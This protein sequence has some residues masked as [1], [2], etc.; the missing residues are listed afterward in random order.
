VT[1]D[2]EV[3]FAFADAREQP[4]LRAS[5]PMRLAA[6]TAA[7]TVSLELAGLWLPDDAVLRRVPQVK[8]A[9]AAE[10]RSANTSPAVFGVTSAA[11]DLLAAAPDAHDTAAALRARLDELRGRAYALAD[12][13]VPHEHV[14]ERLALRARSY[15]LTRAATTAAVVA[16]GGRAMSL[17]GTAQRLARKGRFLL[18]QGQTAAVRRAHLAALGGQRVSRRRTPGRRRGTRPTSGPSRPWPAHPGPGARRRTPP[19]ATN[20]AETPPEIAPT[21]S[22]P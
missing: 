14:A 16:G 20:R 12:H 6:L 11:L 17:D 10:P 21:P 18:I 8:F 19:P 5:A 22:R 9:R 3:V 15:D 4:G 7:R 1:R 2:A 13:L